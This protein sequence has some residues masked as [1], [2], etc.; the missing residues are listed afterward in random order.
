VD[1]LYDKLVHY[2]KEGYYPM[3][4]PGHKRND[5]MMQMVNPYTIDITEIEGFDNLHQAEG[6][7]KELSERL[8]RLYGAERSFPLING[9][10]A[11][12]LAGISAAAGRGDKVLIARNCH[13]SVYHAVE[14]RGL[15]PVYYY[16]PKVKE[17]PVNGGI[18]ACEI[19]DVLIRE[20]NITLVVITSP[21]YEGIVS[22]IR[23]I[24]DVVHRHGAL[25][26]VDEAHGAHFGFHEGFPKSALHEGA[27]IVI[28]SLHKTLPAFT[29]SAVLHSNR[30][31]LDKKIEQYL[32][33]YES[34]SPSYVL[35]AGIDR[36]I[37]ILEDQGDALFA[38]YHKLLNN[39]YREM[40]GL[41][42]LKILKRDLIGNDSI[43][44]MDASKI[45]VSVKD[46]TL[47]GH[48][49]QNILREKYHIIMEMEAPDYILGM[50]S[51]CDTEEGFRRLSEALLT[52]D[53]K[54]SQKTGRKFVEQPMR[55][56]RILLPWEAVELE[57]EPVLLSESS[58]RISA[59]F[60]SMFP[61]GSPLL[62]PGERIDIEM[63][64]KI[65]KIQK[66]GITVTGLKGEKFNQIE[67]VNNK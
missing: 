11:G 9:S 42:N 33:I 41:R 39:F 2:N 65:Q 60:I 21:T 15:I 20:K 44:D 56:I 45:T 29:Q 31:S 59:A 48:Q 35:M 25:L 30:E 49:L 37:S 1:T 27:D 23:A 38:S 28:Q 46:T 26:L 63:I 16:P 54:I 7:L 36:C 51:I 62:V 47:S 14:L 24:S 50:T 19:E 12:I 3:H 34:S 66:E 53:K 43:Y 18:Y 67:V 52:V 13:K 32:A 6:I 40:E 4:M 22:D 64:E 10:T 61:P 57:A 17:I 55:P 8:S 58:G 5:S